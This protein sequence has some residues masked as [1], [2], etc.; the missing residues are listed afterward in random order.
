LSVV[1][2]DVAFKLSTAVGSFMV[3]YSG[4]GI[5]ATLTWPA[6]FVIIP[7][8]Y[9]TAVLQVIHTP[10]TIEI[11]ILRQSSY[12]G[13]KVGLAIFDTNPTQN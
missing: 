1:D 2:L 5:L 4:Y 6:L 9:L 3:A 11:K 8:V 12:I 7:M 10:T 13:L